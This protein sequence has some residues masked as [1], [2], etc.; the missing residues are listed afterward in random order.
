EAATDVVRGYASVRAP[1]DLELS[2]LLPSIRARLCRSLI[3]SAKARRENPD[4]AYLQVSDQGAR[5]LLAALETV[6][7]VWAEGRFRKAAIRASRERLVG[8]SLSL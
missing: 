6:D 8:R 4:N 1:T 5:E 3:M 7:D 2:L